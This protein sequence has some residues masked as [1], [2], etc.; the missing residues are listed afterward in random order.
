MTTPSVAARLVG[1]VL[2]AMGLATAPLTEPAALF[3]ALAVV[4]AVLAI[5]RPRIS[6]LLS[7]GLLALFA[8]VALALPIAL[9][10]PMRGASIA[11]RATLATTAV[12]AITSS[13]PFARLGPALAAL[14]LPRG[15]SAVVTT[16]L[17]QLGS[18]GSEARRLQLAR[19]LRGASGRALSGE[20]VAALLTRSAAR[21]ERA[22]LAMRLRGYDERQKL[23]GTSLVASD[24]ALLCS[25]ALAAALVH[26]A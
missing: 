24:G 16:L 2:L 17:R 26:L 8:I 11:I 18:L 7:R 3:A 5:A 6:T 4:A 12:L 9:S 1:A 10:D 14:G 23:P 20:L 15:F 25:A 21:A 13:I 19:T 22:E